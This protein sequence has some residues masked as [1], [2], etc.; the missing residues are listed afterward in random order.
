MPNDY[1]SINIFKEPEC[2]SK[3]VAIHDF[4]KRILID[5]MVERYKPFIFNQL[6]LQLDYGFTVTNFIIAIIIT[7][8]TIAIII[9]NKD[10]G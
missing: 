1:S 2:V 4:V 3:A 9:V 10:P 5:C 8:T 7:I 6:I